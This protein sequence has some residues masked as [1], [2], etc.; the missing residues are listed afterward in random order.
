MQFGREGVEVVGVVV[1]GAFRVVGVAPG[2]IDSFLPIH[3]FVDS[4]AVTAGGMKIPTSG[5]KN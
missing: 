2:G 4:E 5:D 3:E 1:H